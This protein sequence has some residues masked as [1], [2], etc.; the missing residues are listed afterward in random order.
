MIEF[1]FTLDYE[2]YGDG[3]GTLRELVYEPAEQLQTLFRKWNAQFVAFI[4]VSELE[5]IETYESDQAIHLVKK[6]IQDLYRN[7]HEI[8]LYLHPQWCN[9]LRMQYKLVLDY[10]VFNLW[11]FL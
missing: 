5:K 3:T 10:D 2:I 4:E 7:N 8:D 6:Q 1:I 11:V 9:P